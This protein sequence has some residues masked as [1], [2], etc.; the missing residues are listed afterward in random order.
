[1]YPGQ[2]LLSASFDTSAAADPR[3]VFS[4]KPTSLFRGGLRRFRHREK[5]CVQRHTRGA[6]L[7]LV[8]QQYPQRRAAG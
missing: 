1:M 3:L 6:E 4:R 2:T 5:R 7:K 8:E